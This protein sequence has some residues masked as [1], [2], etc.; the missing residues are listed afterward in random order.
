[1]KKMALSIYDA[2]DLAPADS[3]V[4]I[5]NHLNEDEWKGFVEAHPEGNIFQTPEMFQVFKQTNRFQP[6]LWAAVS[7]ERL[8][9]LFIPVHIR[10][11]DHLPQRFSTRSILYGSVLVSPDILG[12]Q[13]LGD[14]LDAYTNEVEEK[15]LFTELRN[16]YDFQLLNPVFVE[17]GFEYEDHL[18]FLIDLN[19]SPDEVFQSISSNGRKAIRKAMRKGVHAEEVHDRKLIPVFYDLLQHTFTRAGVPLADISLFEAVLDILVPDGKAKMFLANFEGRYIAA[20]LELPYKDVIYS[21]FSGY[22]YEYR[23]LYPNDLLVWHA[24]EWGAMNGYQVYDFGGAGRPDQEYG[25]RD[26]KAKFGGQL[27][28]FGRYTY[29]H[30]PHTLTYSSFFYQIFRSVGIKTNLVRFFHH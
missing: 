1:M 18:N 15:P 25:P 26:F 23:H 10:L 6:D 17:H 4:K 24:L 8:L 12:Y 9:A 16:L 5:V 3:S 27:V 19:K 13:A 22:D 29:V 30:A 28:N 2:I 21:W 14:L 7:Q 11:F 20:S